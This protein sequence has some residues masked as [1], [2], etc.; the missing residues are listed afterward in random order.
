MKVGDLVRVK[1]DL[2]PAINYSLPGWVVGASTRE[3]R[4][5]TLFEFIVVHFPCGRRT[6]FDIEY[7]ELVASIDV[8]PTYNGDAS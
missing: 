3:D 8:V 1:N 2:Y 5:G 7:L 6:S 4:A